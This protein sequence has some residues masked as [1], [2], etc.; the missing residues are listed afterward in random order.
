MKKAGL[1]ISV[2]ILMAAQAIMPAMAQEKRSDDFLAFMAEEAKAI[3]DVASLF[4]ESKLD[5]GSTVSS[6]DRQQWRNLGARRT[7]DAIGQLPGVMLY[8]SF[9]GTDVIAIRGYANELSARGI[10]TV[11]D[12][13]PMNT[14]AWGTAQ[15]NMPNLDLGVLNKIEMIRGPGSAI[16]GSDAFHGVYSLKTFESDEDVLETDFRGAGN[17]YHDAAV[18]LSRGLPGGIRVNAA[19]AGSGQPDQNRAYHYTDPTDFTRKTA[20]RKNKYDSTSGV[21]KIQTD[22]GKTLSSGFELVYNR[23][24]ARQ[25]PGLGRAFTVTGLSYYRG[26]DTTDNDSNVVMGKANVAYKLPN[27][28]V[29]ELTAFYWQTDQQFLY[30]QS[31]NALLGADANIIHQAQSEYRRGASITFKQEENAFRTAWVLSAGYNKSHIFST[32]NEYIR[33]SDGSL[34]NPATRKAYFDGYQHDIV[35]AFFQTKTAFLDDKLFLLLG[36][37]SD[38]YSDFGNQIVPRAGLIFK[39]DADSAVKVVYGKAFRAAVGG[40]VGG[41]SNIKG[42]PEI[43]PETIATYELILMRAKKTY[44]VNVSFFTSKWQDGITTVAFSGDPVFV[45][46]YVN[47]AENTAKGVEVEGKYRVSEKLGFNASGSY[48]ASRS[49]TRDVNYVAFPKYIVNLGAN[50]LLK[51]WDVRLT[52]NN[53]FHLAACKGPVRAGQPGSSLRDYY[54]TDLIAMKNIGRRAVASLEVR[55][56]FGRNNYVPSVWGAEGGVPDEAVSVA[57]FGSL[58]F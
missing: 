26:H 14:L 50:Y 2:S 56:M 27:A 38:T 39:P 48:V 19:L 7:N 42:D 13:V 21:F 46:K 45:S 6:I 34:V 28:I 36:L 3:T 25:F 43:K 44:D 8:P 16:Y 5:V 32:K 12:G 37:R 55:N 17:G 30:D 35:N 41:A 29:A 49:V 54:R 15:Y 51:P 23:Y 58:K 18:R 22:A 24:S 10:A 47:S 57:A 4:K 33:V 40:E 31:A 1:F 9:G 53:R 20:D 11:V 52:L